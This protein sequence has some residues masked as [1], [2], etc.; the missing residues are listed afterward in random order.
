MLKSLCAVVLLLPLPCLAAEL[1]L[2]YNAMERLLAEQLFSQDGRL[3]VRG[4]RTSKC[5]F[6]YLESPRLGTTEHRLQLTARFSGRSALDMFGGCVGLG[7]SFEFTMTAIPVV[8]NGALALDQVNVQSKRDSY[9]IRKV[10]QALTASF[11][12]SFKIEVRDQAKKLLEQPGPP[13]DGERPRATLIR[14]TVL[15]SSTDTILVRLGI[16]WS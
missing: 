5:T 6:A 16:G 15:S 10:K 9:Y 11:A 4:S 1:E 2:R 7:D 14:L 3:Y 8:R 13:A 12:K